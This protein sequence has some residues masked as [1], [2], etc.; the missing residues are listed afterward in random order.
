MGGRQR[1]ELSMP[2][3]VGGALATMTAAVAASY[4]GVAGTVI[5]AAVMSVGSTVGGAVYT[6]YLKRTGDQ[7]TLLV[8]HEAGGQADDDPPRKVEGKG[9][10]AT[11]VQAT[12]RDE[13]PARRVAGGAPVDPD[14]PTSVFPV[15]GAAGQGL[16]GLDDLVLVDVDPATA[17]LPRITGG[18]RVKVWSP[19]VTAVT[20][21][22]T[23]ALGMGVILGFEGLTGQP[24]S[25]TIKGEQG[26]GTSLNPGADKRDRRP[27]RV[28]QSRP[29]APSSPAATP[30]ETAGPAATTDPGRTGSPSAEPT[31]EP[32]GSPTPPARTPTPAPTATLA[33]VDPEPEPTADPT[34]PQ[35]PG[36]TDLPAQEEVQG[37]GT[38]DRQSP[39]E[40]Q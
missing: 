36:E 40:G 27:E 37:D 2:Q 3:I 39:S 26:S 12:I 24:V 22:V 35:P 10:L 19:A 32:T 8:G 13:A 6:H 29:A 28:K 38:P 11:A 23:F 7:L 15:V 9:E 33:P 30:D 18:P 4:L 17:E 21:V 1:F 20:A 25:S 5:G 34:G 31:A 14:A 16:D